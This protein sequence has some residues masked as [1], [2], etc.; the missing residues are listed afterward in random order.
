MSS[1]SRFAR[2]WNVTL[3]RARR[4]L[5]RQRRAI[6]SSTRSKWKPMPVCDASNSTRRAFRKI[7]R[8]WSKPWRSAANRCG[9]E[10]YRAAPIASLSG[11]ASRAAKALRVAS[12][13]QEI[14]V[15]FRSHECRAESFLSEDP[16]ERLS[17]KRTVC[18][19]N[20][21]ESDVHDPVD[22]LDQCGV[23][24]E[25]IRWTKI[26]L[27]AAIPPTIHPGPEPPPPRG[28]FFYWPSVGTPVVMRV[29]HE[30]LRLQDA[31]HS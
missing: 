20:V 12:S 8:R 21:R 22:E 31:F 30:P 3:D 24:G 17:G 10:A 14:E 13:F 7:W 19:G 11:L 2:H 1:T 26:R 15:A 6:R 29:L 25:R 5:H 9:P 28:D 4:R 18:T 27:P 23:E 16:V